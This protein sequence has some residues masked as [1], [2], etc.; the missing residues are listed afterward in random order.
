[1]NPWRQEETV[2]IGGAPFVLAV[3]N[4]KLAGLF[5][6]LGATG[7]PDVYAKWDAMHPDDMKTTL[8]WLALEEGRAAAAFDA[9]T[10]VEGMLELQRG[11]YRVVSGKPADQLS[12]EEDARKKL[13]AAPG[14]MIV[15]IVRGLV[16]AG[17][18]PM[19]GGSTSPA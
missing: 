13:E 18:I 1:M 11:F 19:P 3:T 5:A 2:T 8:Q 7:W 15:A 6:A 17:A 10:G 14:E 9:V 12:A 16:E 4:G